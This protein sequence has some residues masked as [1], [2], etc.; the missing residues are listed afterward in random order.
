[1]ETGL[2]DFP[3]RLVPLGPFPL[4]S[5]F[6]SLFECLRGSS[7]VPCSLF[8]YIVHEAAR[9]SSRTLSF[10]GRLIAISMFSIFDRLLR[11]A[12]AISGWV[13]FRKSAEVL[14]N[15][16]KS[17][18]DSDKQVHSITMCVDSLVLGADGWLRDFRQAMERATAW[19][20]G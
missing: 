12:F 7:S 2:F 20:S 5:P 8:V 10:R 4:T 11:V 17:V 18:E 19:I 3:D 13:F 16:M 6:P 14:V 15:L 9:I 1:M